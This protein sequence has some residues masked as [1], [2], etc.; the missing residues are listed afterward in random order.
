[1]HLSAGCNLFSR[2]G[3]QEDDLFLMR[4]VI[5]VL[6]IPSNVEVGIKKLSD[7]FFLSQ[8]FCTHNNL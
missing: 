6:F 8:K 2:N 1:M 3:L 7:L 4:A 5:K